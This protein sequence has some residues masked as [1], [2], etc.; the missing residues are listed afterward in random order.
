MALYKLNQGKI[1]GITYNHL[2][3]VLTTTGTQINIRIAGDQQYFIEA[4]LTEFVDE[5]DDVFDDVAAF[6]TYWDTYYIYPPVAP[7]EE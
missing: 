2:P 1:N 3:L 6:I 4:D 5:S 7:V